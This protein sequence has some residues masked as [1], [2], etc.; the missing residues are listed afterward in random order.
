L[1]SI[2]NGT[3]QAADTG[4]GGV[5]PGAETNVL[6]QPLLTGTRTIV[7]QWSTA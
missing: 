4:T 3:T 1:I 5:L 6:V 2:K 7:E